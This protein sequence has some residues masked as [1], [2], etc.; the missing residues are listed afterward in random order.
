MYVVVLSFFHIFFLSHLSSPSSSF[1]WDFFHISYFSF[2]YARI[3][4][5]YRP[6]FSL[7]HGFARFYSDSLS[8]IHDKRNITNFVHHLVTTEKKNLS[9]NETP[10]WI[11]KAH[12][13][14]LHNFRNVC[15]PLFPSPSKT[16]ARPKNV[17][18]WN[19]PFELP[20]K[21]VKCT[22]NVSGFLNAI[23]TNSFKWDNFYV[24]IS[25]KFIYFVILFYFVLVFGSQNNSQNA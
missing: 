8:G 9:V 6:F 18:I 11:K 21:C 14:Y 1:S 3:F 10:Q 23:T 7:C 22:R 20:K 13:A 16:K 19:S 2:Q 15:F 17:W 12:N 25:L 24:F 4:M 5:D